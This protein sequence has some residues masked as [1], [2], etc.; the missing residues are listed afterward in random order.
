MDRSRS[1][2]ESVSWVLGGAQGSSSRAARRPRSHYELALGADGAR[3]TRLR[4]PRARSRSGARPRGRTASASRQ[5]RPPSVCRRFDCEQRLLPPQAPS[6]VSPVR[7]PSSSPASLTPPP[8]VRISRSSCSSSC[9]LGGAIAPLGAPQAFSCSACCRVLADCG[10]AKSTSRPSRSCTPDGDHA[11]RA[12]SRSAGTASSAQRR[13]RRRSAGFRTAPTPSRAGD[14]AH[15]VGQAAGTPGSPQR[16]PLAVDGRARIDHGARRSERLRQDDRP[17]AKARPGTT[18]TRRRPGRRAEGGV[19][20]TLQSTALFASLTPLRAH[21]LVRARQ[22]RRRR[23]RL[24][25]DAR[26]DAA[27]AR[28]EEAATRSGR[29]PR[30]C[31]G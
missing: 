19:V 31:A 1:P 26:V 7:S 2:P 27:G 13:A 3:R 24:H 29:R 8:T 9:P 22:R 28:Q 15:G 5:P 12:S 11:S 25:P 21:Y 20:R 6:R 4:R 16:K 10:L 14:T 18:R 23:R 17:A 30:V